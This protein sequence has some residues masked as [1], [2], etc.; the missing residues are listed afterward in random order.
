MMMILLLFLQKQNL[1]N[2]DACPAHTRTHNIENVFHHDA[3][4]PRTKWVGGRARESIV[5]VYNSLT[6]VP[7]TK[8]LGGG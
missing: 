4:P 7:N 2:H 5:V 3:C 8:V 6:V 1:G